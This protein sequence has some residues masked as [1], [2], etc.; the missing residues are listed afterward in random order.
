[1]KVIAFGLLAV[2]ACLNAYNQHIPE[3]YLLQYQQ[4]FS[5]IKSLNDFSMN[6]P[7]SWGISRLGKNSFLNFNG[8]DS[9]SNFPLN[10]A[11]LK[12]KVFGDF[13]LETD[14]LAVKETGEKGTACLFLGIRDSSRYYFVKL[15]SHDSSARGI[16][17]V[18]DSVITPLYTVT[19][20][21][22][23][24]NETPAHK[25]RLE[26]NIVRRTITVFIDNVESPVFFVKDYELVMGG[27]GIGTFSGHARFDNIKIWAPTV[28]T[29]AQLK[30]MYGK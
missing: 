7:W 16:Y 25:I 5:N 26:R 27:L 28:I 12:N 29:D 3:G 4:D 9:A 19:D 15:V 17:L 1:M 6:R 13:I 21:L 20:S 18:Q 2:I 30:E 24:W 23:R 11:V 10:R 8:S 22:S 14:I